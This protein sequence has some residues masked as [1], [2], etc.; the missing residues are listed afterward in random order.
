LAGFE[1]IIVGRFCSDHR[2]AGARG[3]RHI[4]TFIYVI[5]QALFDPQSNGK[6]ERWHKSLKGE[7]IRSGTPLSLGDARRL[8]NGY[9]EHYPAAE[10]RAIL[11]QLVA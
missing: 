3:V 7:S 5:T 6:I 2:G 1:V 8:I 10:A 9:M 4:N 11:G